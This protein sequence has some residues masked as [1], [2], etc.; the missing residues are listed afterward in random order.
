MGKFMRTILAIGMILGFV[1]VLIIALL[2]VFQDLLER[3][4]CG[5]LSPVDDNE[6]PGHR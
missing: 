4:S 6:E 3:T 1:A 5:P 2:S